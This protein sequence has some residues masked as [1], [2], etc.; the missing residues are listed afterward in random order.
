MTKQ[1]LDALLKAADASKAKDGW[2]E[3]AAGRE[4]TLYVAAGSANL[5]VSRITGVKE[6][7]ALLEARSAKGEHYVLALETVFA[8]AV[9]ES[10]DKQR[11]AGF[12]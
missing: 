10:N 2:R 7:A 11:K 1:H 9:D 6:G 12:V 5:T 3:I 4:L 8:G